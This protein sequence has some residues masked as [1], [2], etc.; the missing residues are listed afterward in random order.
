MVEKSQGWQRGDPIGYIRDDI[1]Q[2]EMPKCSGQHYEALVP[3]T[4]DLQERAALAVN[5][6]TGPTD[7]QADY[8]IYWRVHF[9]SNPPLMFHSIDDHVQAKFWEALPLVRMVSGSE[10]NLDVQRRWL[11]VMLHMQGP[12]GLLYTPVQGRPWALPQHPEPA[13]SLD[14][15]PTGDQFCTV[16]MVGRALATFALY[17]LLDAAGPWRQAA[18][19]LV[20][21][22]CNLAVA[23][24]NYAYLPR[25]FVEPGQTF[26]GEAQ[27]PTAF[28]AGMAGWIIQGLSQCYRALRYEPA[29]TLAGQM[30]RYL[31]QQGEFIAPDGQFLPDYLPGEYVGEHP[32]FAADP[33]AVARESAHFH[34]HTNGLMAALEYVEASGDQDF[35]DWTRQGYEYARGHGEP[36]LGWFPER[37][38]SRVYAETSET[39]QVADMI[40]CAIKLSLLGD[41]RWDDVDRWVRNQLAENQLVQ[42]DWIYRAAADLPQAHP[43][44]NETIEN[45]PERNVGAF[46]GWP[47][48]NDWIY[49]PDHPHAWTRGIMHCCTGNGAR[50][51]YYVWDNILHYEDGHLR[52]NL[53][54]NRASPWADVDSHIPYTGQVDVKVK[55]ACDLSIRIPEW[56]R[57]EQVQCQVNGS[58]RDLGWQGRY[59][60]VGAVKPDDV[61]TMTFPLEVRTDTVYIEQQRYR[62]VRK[63]N[64]VV[65]ID[66]PGPNWPLYQRAHYRANQ[67][68][69][70]RMTR[71]IADTLI[72]W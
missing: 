43:A 35:L 26:S 55:Q 22:L 56:V 24:D 61:A 27:P 34:A 38:P 9:R 10:Q 5:G 53:L 60:L 6:L 18:Q 31:V 54:L 62:L 50:A 65:V 39:C 72:H 71:F 66:P 33:F 52:V 15:L 48:P 25:N 49:Y 28:R 41:D 30:L 12:D 37:I 7:P 19:R 14:A 29:L 4:L 17:A 11:E 69:W 44:F 8:E 51:L 45:V 40:T 3:D 1:P 2:F 20:D 46:A 70:K 42:C 13:S 63:G 16:G 59:A 67:T 47:A 23:Q 58:Q 57:P 68:R 64:D 36:L 21:G 32:D